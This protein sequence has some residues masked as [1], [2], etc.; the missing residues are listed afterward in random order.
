MT[1]FEFTDRFSKVDVWQIAFD[2]LSRHREEL[3]AVQRSQLWAGRNLAGELLKPTILEDPFFKGNTRW[4]KWWAKRKDEQTQHGDD[5]EFGIRPYGIANLIFSSG[6]V[7]WN[8]IRVFQAGKDLFIGT[9][10]NIQPELEAKYGELFGLNPQGVAYV[11]RE[12]FK[13]EFCRDFW[14]AILE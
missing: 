5:A 14:N 11:M 13:D 4:A 6:V 3:E 7:V 8:P 12:F 2:V 9:D 1:I 10:M